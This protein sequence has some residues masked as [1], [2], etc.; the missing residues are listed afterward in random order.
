MFAEG[1]MGVTIYLH[2]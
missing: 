1:S 2:K